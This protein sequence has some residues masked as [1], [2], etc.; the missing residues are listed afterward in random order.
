M[1]ILDRIEDFQKEIGEYVITI[2]NFDGV[3]RGHQTVLKKVKSLAEPDKK[4]IVITFSNHPS[5][6]LRPEQTTPLLCSLS[7]RIQLIEQSKIDF[8]IC[9]PFTKQFAKQSAESFIEKLKTHIP[10]SHMVLGYDAT[11]GNH[12]RG[13][14][15]NLK[16]IAMEWGFEITYV[17]EYRYEGHPVSSTRIRE[18]VKLGD[19]STV[20]SLLNRPY[21]IKS[22]VIKG[23]NL[24]K[25]IGFPTANLNVD[26]ICLP[27][28]G[29]YAVD[30]VKNG[31]KVPG[32]A[33]LGVA[34]TIRS[35]GAPLLEVHL[36]GDPEQDF[37]EETLEVVF[38]EFIRE[39]RKFVDVESLKEQISSDILYA[40]AECIEETKENKN[41]RI[42]V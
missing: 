37:Y 28:L 12:R 11:I 15:N 9:I 22:K 20:E 10:F 13:N 29:V 17:E 6:I 16:Q 39:E 40:K 3:H 41:P 27:P 18:A 2:G 25:N 4:S 1:Q 5:E 38:K 26:G 8:L 32:I 36:F 33:N 14:R 30:V 21:S 24:G 34:P 42:P 19:F 23:A 31:A 35:D 7:H